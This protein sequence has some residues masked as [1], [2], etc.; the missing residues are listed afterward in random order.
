MRACLRAKPRSLA[1]QAALRSRERGARGLQTLLGLL[2]GL[3]QEQVGLL[4]L[5]KRLQQLPRLLRGNKG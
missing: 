3:D 2:R 1:A 5:R 4:R